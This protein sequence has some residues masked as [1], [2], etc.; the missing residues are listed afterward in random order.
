MPKHGGS[1]FMSVFLYCT[2]LGE[3]LR[4]MGSCAHGVIPR[5][6]PF[7]LVALPPLGHYSHPHVHTNVQEQG[8]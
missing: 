6:D 2:I 5:L 4:L 3:Q 8:R 7:H 1:K